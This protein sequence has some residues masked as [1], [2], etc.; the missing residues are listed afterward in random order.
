MDRRLEIAARISIRSQL[1]SSRSLP[2]SSEAAYESSNDAAQQSRASTSCHEGLR[3]CYG[4]ALHKAAMQGPK[5]V[6]ALAA[7]A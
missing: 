5:K 6:V 1:P 4:L 2:T 3:I 7:G